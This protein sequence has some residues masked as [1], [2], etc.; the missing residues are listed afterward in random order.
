M[1]S[2]YLFLAL[3]GATAFQAHSLKVRSFTEEED[4]AVAALETSNE[5]TAEAEVT[6]DTALEQD[7]S[8]E[9]SIKM[10]NGVGWLRK[11]GGVDPAHKPNLKAHVKSEDQPVVHRN[12]GRNREKHNKFAKEKHERLKARHAA[13]VAARLAAAKA[14]TGTGSAPTGKLPSLASIFRKTNKH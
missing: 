5:S 8:M 10:V 3:L 4:L 1:A 6:I 14:A 12:P 9:A 11:Q 7:A 2:K 13:R